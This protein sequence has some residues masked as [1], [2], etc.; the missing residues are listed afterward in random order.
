MISDASKLSGVFEAHKVS[1]KGEAMKKKEE[2]CNFFFVVATCCE[3]HKDSHS[4]HSPEKPQGVCW[5]WV[6]GKEITGWLGIRVAVGG[7]KHGSE[8]EHP[9]HPQTSQH[10]KSS[11][12]GI[13][14]SFLMC[15]RNSV[16]YK[17]QNIM[18][19]W[20]YSKCE[21]VV[22]SGSL[23]GWDRFS[24]MCFFPQGFY[25]EVVILIRHVKEL[26]FAP[27]MTTQR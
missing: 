18:L 26:L 1:S 2:A 24:F 15:V 8:N 14:V 19:L 9:E 3:L 21:S 6:S 20:Q 22:W 4:E 11:G 23:K 27:Y 13:Y 7:E 5:F 17:V 25:T 12:I 10:R 16:W